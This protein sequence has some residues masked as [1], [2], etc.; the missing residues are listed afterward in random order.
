MP[1]T[2]MKSYC[3]ESYQ[4]NRE[5]NW[6]RS[7][8][9]IEKDIFRLCRIHRKS[10]WTA[11]G[12][13]LAHIFCMTMRCM[14][15]GRFLRYK[16]NRTSARNQADT[17]QLYR[18]HKRRSQGHSKMFRSCKECNLKFVSSHLQI[19]TSLRCIGNKW[20]RILEICKFFVKIKWNSH[21]AQP[22]LAPKIARQ[23]LPLTQRTEALC[24]YFL[25]SFHTMI[26][27]STLKL[28]TTRLTST[29]LSRAGTKFA[30]ARKIRSSRKSSCWTRI[31]LDTIL[32]NLGHNLP[33]KTVSPLQHT[34]HCYLCT[35]IPALRGW[36]FEHV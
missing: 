2:P 23:N 28:K 12:I 15:I 19:D 21:M 1:R 22:H 8:V 13:Y 33:P 25:S 5:Y 3:F 14:Q 32:T 27:S 6:I 29:R 20:V 16:T 26:C 30:L 18:S 34:E 31:Q 35:S 9:L 24:L 36:N 10:S 4:G 17:F 11:I 7:L